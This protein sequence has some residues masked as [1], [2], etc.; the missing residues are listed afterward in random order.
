MGPSTPTSKVS[1]DMRIPRTGVGAPDRSISTHSPA[2]SPGGPGS[3]AVVEVDVGAVDVGAAEVEVLVEASFV[4]VCETVVVEVFESS[5]SA[6]TTRGTTTAAAMITTAAA[7]RATHRPVRLFL[8]GPG[9]VAPYP[10]PA[11]GWY[12][13]VGCNGTL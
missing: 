13:S 11:G 8:P 2:E 3:A 6:S 4:V 9:G 12:G 1:S 7:A 5:S 10:G